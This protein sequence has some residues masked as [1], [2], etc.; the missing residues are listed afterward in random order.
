MRPPPPAVAD[1][2][3]IDEREPEVY[4]IRAGESN[5]VKVGFSS[6]VQDRMKYLQI[7][8]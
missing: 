4:F 8:R 2:D 3:D 5:A 6:D 1:D 7:A